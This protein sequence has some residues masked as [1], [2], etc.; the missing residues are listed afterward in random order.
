MK[1]YLTP[2]I[3]IFTILGITACGKSSIPSTYYSGT[4]TINDRYTADSNYEGNIGKAT[5]NATSIS[6]NETTFSNDDYISINIEQISDSL[7]YTITK[8][9]TTLGSYSF[10]KASLFG[11]DFE[12]YLKDI[13]A[14]GTDDFTIIEHFTTGS[15][16][17]SD[18]II[19]LN[20]VTADCS[21]F[22]NGGLSDA[23]IDALLAFNNAANSGLPNLEEIKWGSSLYG[24]INHEDGLIIYDTY[25]VKSDS[26]DPAYN[27]KLTYEITEDFDLNLID[28]D[29]NAIE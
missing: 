17:G 10:D 25:S 6:E 19:L 23:Q 18:R 12:I 21:S 1:Y 9:D 28:T 16:S 11:S 27:L 24:I 20:T 4:L 7:I 8:S 5:C 14:D 29:Y 3:L 22:M 13:N 15:P 26:L 2:F